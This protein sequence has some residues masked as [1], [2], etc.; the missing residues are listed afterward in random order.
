ML[1]LIKKIILYLR[2]CHFPHAMTDFF[3]LNCYFA[4]WAAIVI[5]ITTSWPIIVP[6]QNTGFYIWLT[7][8]IISKECNTVIIVITLV[9]MMLYAISVDVDVFLKASR[10]YLVIMAA[11]ETTHNHII[12]PSS[13]DY[14]SPGSEE[15]VWVDMNAFSILRVM[16]IHVNV[17]DFV[18]TPAK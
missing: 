17:A 10:Y 6:H 14:Y 4:C 16:R 3:P 2:L 8:A 13:K 12:L 7:P 1:I 18:N 11:N 15:M 5:Q 9:W